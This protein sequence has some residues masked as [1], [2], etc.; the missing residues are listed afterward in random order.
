MSAPTILFRFGNIQVHLLGVMVAVGFL[1]GAYT[2]VRLAER[3]GY[4]KE[5]VTDLLL[6][7][8]LGGL[9][10][11]RMLYV[12][13]NVGYYLQH[14]L[15]ILSVH[16]GGL[17]F[18][19]AVFGGAAV[20]L[21]HCRKRR[22][23]FL[24]FADTLVPGLALGYAI[25]RIGCDIYGNVTR[26]PW[27][28]AVNGITRH[29]VQLYSALAGYL[30]FILLLER[31]RQQRFDGEIF[32]LFVATYSVYRFVIEFFRSTSPL[33]SNAQILSVV[34]AVAG[35]LFWLALRKLSPAAQKGGA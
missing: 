35:F 31:S 10:G 24:R 5:K 16:Q 7:M 28:V 15:S 34:A 25:G 12:L 1:A 8:L 23:S 2:A 32:L 27:G 13:Q 33:F 17:S 20:V 3:K 30:I 29:P 9:A 18:H 22:I 4:D 21:A 14:P 26:V 11:A 19:G 6:Y